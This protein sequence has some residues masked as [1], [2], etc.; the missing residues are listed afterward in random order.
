MF[1]LFGKDARRGQRRAFKAIGVC[2][3]SWLRG[4]GKL[5]ELPKLR[6]AKT[7]VLNRPKFGGGEGAGRRG[8]H[9]Q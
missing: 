2:L 9:P 1:L 6:S 3:N 4:I 5:G 7:F 8:L